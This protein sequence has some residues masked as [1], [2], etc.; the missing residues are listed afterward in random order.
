MYVLYVYKLHKH[1]DELQVLNTFTRDFINSY[2]NVA[3]YIDISM[4]YTFK[5][6]LVK[7]YYTHSLNNYYT[8]INVHTCVAVLQ[9]VI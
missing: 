5:E 9:G 7:Q 2:S 3:L 6:V 4:W 8:H 1:A